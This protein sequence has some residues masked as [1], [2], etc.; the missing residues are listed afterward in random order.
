[1][2]GESAVA[3]AA[4]ALGAWCAGGVIA[5]VA[6]DWSSR[7]G[8]FAPAWWLGLLLAGALTL[9]AF[10]RPSP[11]SVAPLWVPLVSVLPWL[12]VPL[13]A[14]AMLGVG[15]LGQLL[16]ATSALVCLVAVAFE[17]RGVFDA[18]T[19][20]ATP[21][22]LLAALFS[23][24]AWWVSPRIPGGDEPHYLIITQSLLSDGDLRIEDNH[25]RREYAAYADGELKPD[26]L[27][28]GRDGAIYSIHAPG[29]SA[30]VLPAFWLA[31]YRGA[32]FTVVVLSALGLI[33]VWRSAVA[34]T[35][36]AGAAAIATAGV[37]LSVPFFFQAFT[38][39]PDG[40]AAV[41]VAAVVWL[42]LVRPGAP[43]WLS[44]LVCGALLGVLPW[45]HTRY[46][47]IASPLGLVVAGRLLW[48]HMQSVPWPSRMRALVAFALPALLSVVAWLMM[49]QA[50]YG[51]WDPRAPYGH[52]TDMRWARIPHG[53]AG[54]LL[55][56]QFGVLPNAPIYL[57][58]LGG[59]AAL[60]RRDRRLTASCWSSPCPT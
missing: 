40:P 7:I 25:R 34:V 55:D 23:A 54:L 21:V 12:P 36:S 5:P 16:A 43:T 13:P 30:L 10:A 22:L 6:A 51:T 56:Q 3:A 4:W 29:V 35:G 8:A 20:A 46:G 11:R 27:R 9:V 45:L 17:R 24:A 14:A 59:F 19:R 39:Y 41:A 28:R 53:V 50:I 1:M 32:V 37:G 33:V 58:A 52:A 44:A 15:P 57:L 31:G 2:R 18:R 60:W 26:Y 49:F 38:I 47:A 48:P 42:A